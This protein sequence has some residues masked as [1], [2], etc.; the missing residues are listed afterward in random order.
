MK[1]I[2]VGLCGFGTVGTGENRDVPIFFLTFLPTRG[3]NVAHSFPP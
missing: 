2:E 1:E 3:D